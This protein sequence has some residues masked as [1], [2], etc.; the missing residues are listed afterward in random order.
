MSFTHLN[1]NP[2]D[3]ID[4]ISQD[5]L[6]RKTSFW[7]FEFGQLQHLTLVSRST[8][9]LQT[10]I[11]WFV[12]YHFQKWRYIWKYLIEINLWCKTHLNIFI[13]S[14]PKIKVTIH[15]PWGIDQRSWPERN[16]QNMGFH[17]LFEFSHFSS[18][19]DWGKILGV[20]SRNLYT[21]PKEFVLRI[22]MEKLRHEEE[23]WFSKK[24]LSL[25]LYT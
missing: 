16:F 5:D 17:F 18:N 3:V 20:R 21:Q 2:S 22:S 1:L 13:F 12:L 6:M 4:S 15:L 7:Y 11:S 10:A 19:L 9:I 14:P 25:E 23:S 24:N 8:K